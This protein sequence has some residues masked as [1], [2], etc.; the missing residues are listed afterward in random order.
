M[1]RDL[2]RFNTLCTRI[3]EANQDA[4]LMQPLA[5]FLEI[6]RF[7]AE[8]RDWY[9]LPMLGCIWS[10]PTDQMLKFPRGHN[11]PFLPQPRPASGQQP[12]GMA[13]RDRRRL[14]LCGKITAAIADKRLNTRCASSVNPA[15]CGGLRVITD[16]GGKPSTP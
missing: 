7:S 14:Q 8:F 4:A 12:A 16:A 2:V 13:H 3:A 10:C 5:A 11:D 15:C 6:H 9:F 1:L